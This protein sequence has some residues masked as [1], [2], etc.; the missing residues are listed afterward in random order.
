MYIQVGKNKI[1]FDQIEWFKMYH[2]SDD[3]IVGKKGQFHF[4]TYPYR[5]KEDQQI[6]DPY[7]PYMDQEYLDSYKF[8]PLSDSIPIVSIIK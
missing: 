4:A 6:F 2:L 1:K 5:L 7:H 3:R 8:T